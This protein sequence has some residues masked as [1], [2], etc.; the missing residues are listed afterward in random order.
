[1]T[2]GQ[3]WFNKLHRLLK[4]MPDGIEIVVDGTG[5]IDLLNEGDLENAFQATGDMMKANT[6]PI[7]SF[8]VER[9]IGNSE[10]C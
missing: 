4:S 2:D 6:Q 7:D 3:K 9:V 5:N 8:Q 1:M 10:S